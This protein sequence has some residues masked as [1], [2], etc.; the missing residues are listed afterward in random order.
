MNQIEL[1]K[2]IDELL[3]SGPIGVEPTTVFDLIN[4]NLD[5]HRYFFSS[6]DEK[7]LDW[8]WKNGFLEPIKKKSQ[9]PTR[10]GYT[11]PE[12]YYLAKMAEK[13]P[14]KVVDIILDTPISK[15][16]FNPEVIDQFLRICTTLPAGELAR[17]INK[18]LNDEWVVLMGAF[19]DFGFQYEKIFEKLAEAKDY[20]NILV[21][22]KAVLSVNPNKRKK[23]ESFISPS[24]KPFY[25]ND[26]SYTKVFKYI[27]S[28][29][30]DYTQE[31]LGIVSGVMD[32]IVLMGGESEKG[33]TFPI[34]ETYHLLD[35]DFF[36]LQ[37]DERERL[38]YRDDVRELAATLKI[39]TEKLIRPNCSDHK[40]VLDIYNKYIGSIPLSTSIWRLRMFILSTCPETFKDLLK[41]SFFRL[42]KEERYHNIVSGT[43]YEKALESSFNVLTESDKREYIKNVFDY[44]KKR[45]E[46]DKDKPWHMEHGSEI[47]SVLAKINE[48]TSEEKDL[49]H[50]YGFKLNLEYE[51]KPTIGESM[52]G[53]I[54]PIAPLSQEE[55]K[56]LSINDIVGK[57]KDEWSPKK[58]SEKYKNEDFL[59]PRNAEGISD[60][61][62]SDMKNRLQDYV[63]KSEFFFDRDN[64]DPQYTYAF[65]RGIEE[66]IKNNKDGIKNI[67]WDNLISLLNTIKTTGEEQTL[68]KEKRDRSSF[69]GWLADW[70]EVHSAMTDVIQA[71]LREEGGVMVI[72]FS[73]YRDEIFS[74]ISYLLTYPDPIPE[75]EEPKTAKMTTTSPGEKKQVVVDPFSM[76]IN[77]VRGRAFQALVLFIYPDSKNIK[78][79]SKISP[80]VKALYERVLK[81]EN[82]RALMFM[83]GHYLPSFYFRDIE[84]AHKLLP[85]IFPD[86]EDKKELYIAAWEGYL[87]NNLYKEMFDNADFQKLYQKALTLDMESPDRKYFRDPDEGIATHLA[88]ALIHYKECDFNHPLFKAFWDKKDPKLHAQFVSFIGRSFVSGDNHVIDDFLRKE[89]RGKE[90]IRIIW[91]WILNNCSEQG[92]FVDFGFWISLKKDLF[93]SNWLADKVKRTLEK[94]D[95]SLGWDYG[96]TQTINELVKTSPADALRISELYLLEG[97]VRKAKQRR[98]FHVDPEWFN[99][100]KSLY[101]NPSTKLGTYKLIDDLIREGGQTFWFLK[102]IVE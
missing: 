54:Q 52:G 10:Y 32:Q 86:S 40:K 43:E 63:D 95:G 37:P 25:F 98:I 57:L 88:L 31:A 46:E 14:N 33:D 36:R 17:V 11:T 2:K 67:N 44:F 50:K 7:W 101:E 18:I 87:A 69:D 29:D 9:D 91:E 59:R 77:S 68:A 22:A 99:A 92:P 90:R 55:F 83:F 38:S 30:D 28:V 45:S 76:A 8:L 78:S 5:T 23:K 42:F 13:D 60:T 65:L 51:P 79:D 62:R 75:D 97:G 73:Q 102:S 80:D 1:H 39:L 56:T 4:S 93:E 64:I 27:L 66:V 26:L 6:A 24:E 19:N 20:K 16:T 89:P 15:E 58:L 21:L 96:L 85:S 94:T 12:V 100:L 74:V 49:A 72:D 53:I 82:T 61:L 3:G 70:S 35:V 48:L 71:L 81:V 41:E 47:L 34:E 84:W